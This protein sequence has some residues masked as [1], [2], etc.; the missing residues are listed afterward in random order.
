[1]PSTALLTIDNRAFPV[2]NDVAADSPY[3]A[4]VHR[5]PG[6]S[7]I[8][9]SCNNS[10]HIQ[11]FVELGTIELMIDGAAG[12]L[13]E[14]DSASVPAGA[15][16]AMRNPADALARVLTLP[17]YEARQGGTMVRVTIAA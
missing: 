14:G 12:H 4:Q 7:Q 5:L 17:I 16:Y 8:A 2:A 6:S 3:R 15:A 11:V 13:G 9:A 10:A 1:M